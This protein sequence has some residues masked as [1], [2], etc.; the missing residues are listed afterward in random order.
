[1]QAPPFPPRDFCF[2]GRVVK[3]KSRFLRIRDFVCSL[4]PP[5]AKRRK[6]KERIQ[7]ADRR[8]TTSATAVAAR[9]VQ[10]RARLSASCRGSRQGDSWSPRLCIRPCFGRQSG[11]FS[12]V[13][14][15]QP[16]AETSRFSAGVTR[17]G[18]TN[19]RNRLRTVSTS[20]TGHSAG[21]MMP[22]AA[23]ERVVSPPAGTALAPL[24]ALPSA[25]GV[26]HRAR[27]SGIWYLNRGQ[28]SRIK[29]QFF[30]SKT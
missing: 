15:P 11:A 2:A 29:A 3:P 23:R 9:A 4:H 24:S 28:L 12:P 30:G 21:T 7:N 1:V 13:R 22:D 10:G 5:P 18:K 14:P 8:S 27:F 25:E 19:E 6:N 20:H 17:A 26:L 16:G